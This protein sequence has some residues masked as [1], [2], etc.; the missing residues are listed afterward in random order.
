MTRDGMSDR[1]VAYDWIWRKDG[2]PMTFQKLYREALEVCS[3]ELYLRHL[4]AKTLLVEVYMHGLFYNVHDLRDRRKVFRLIEQAVVRA[5]LFERR[6][7][8]P[9]RTPGAPPGCNEVIGAVQEAVVRE[10]KKLQEAEQQRRHRE[11]VKHVQ[12]TWR[13]MWSAV[14]VMASEDQR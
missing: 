13:A 8:L 12:N 5:Y 6:S 3:P 2:R 10:A 7:G 9:P 14:A 4:T 11:H 1:V